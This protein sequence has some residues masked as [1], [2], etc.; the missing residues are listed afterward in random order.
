MRLLTAWEKSNGDQ[1]NGKEKKQ[2]AHCGRASG[3]RTKVVQDHP[4]SPFSI[5]TADAGGHE[6]IMPGTMPRFWRK[7]ISF[8]ATRV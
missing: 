2:E 6:S 4:S 5:R 7:A 3:S 8:L 1:A